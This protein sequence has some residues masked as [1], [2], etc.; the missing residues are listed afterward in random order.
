[1]DDNDGKAAPTN[2]VWLGPLAFL[3]F[4]ILFL[5]PMTFM[6]MVHRTEAGL[7]GFSF[8]AYLLL[9]AVLL[10]PVILGTVVCIPCPLLDKLS[11][12]IESESR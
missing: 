8:L 12:L 10:A 9:F 3:A 6:I 4:L 11:V 5:S 7:L 1:M 2:S